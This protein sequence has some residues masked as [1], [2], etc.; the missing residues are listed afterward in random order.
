MAG[1]IKIIPAKIIISL[2][3]GKT[4]IS[5]KAINGISKINNAGKKINRRITSYNVCYT[6]LLRN[7]VIPGVVLEKLE[8]ILPRRYA[9]ARAVYHKKS[10]TAGVCRTA[11]RIV[12]FV[13]GDLDIRQFYLR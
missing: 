7:D 3:L 13:S 12:Y 6:K 2:H 5:T 4:A 8:L 1:I 10:G 9:L 11:L